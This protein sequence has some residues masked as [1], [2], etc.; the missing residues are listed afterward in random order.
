MRPNP[1]LEQAFL[2]N[3]ESLGLEVS[4]TIEQSRGSTDGANV[5]QVVPTL[6][7]S[8]AIVPQEIKS[9]TAEFAEASFSDTGMQAMIHGA[10]ALA[11]TAV[12]VFS[13]ENLFNQ[14]KDHFLIGK[15]GDSSSEA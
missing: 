6:H 8:V 5:S 15:G 9:H 4:R 2:D 12:D 13:S 10:K 3:L 1:P 7:G 14:I 11:M